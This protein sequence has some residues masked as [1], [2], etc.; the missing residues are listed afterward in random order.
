M[1]R[2][3]LSLL[4]LGAVILFAT[5]RSEAS[6]S[7]ALG[8]GTLVKAARMEILSGGKAI[9]FVTIPAGSPMIVLSSQDDGFLVKRS[10]A[11]APFKV[12]K[13]SLEVSVLASNS[14]ANQ[15]SGTS[16]VG[17]A[18]ASAIAVPSSSPPPA[19]TTAPATQPLP[20]SSPAT[21]ASTNSTPTAAQVNKALGIPLFGS[22]SLWEESD[23]MV[24]N[25]LRWP[26]ESKTSTEAGY[27]RYPYT[28]NS[29]TRVLGARSLSLFMQGLNDKV[30]RISILFANK[31]DVAF[32][33]SAQ[34]AKQQAAHEKQ[35]LNVTDSMIKGCQDAMRTDKSAVES[36]LKALLGGSKP[37]RVGKF[38][39]TTEAGQR[40]D[41]SGHS[42]LLFAPQNEYVALRIVPTSTLDDPDAV[43]KSFSSVRATLTN[44]V[45]RRASGDVVITDLPMVDQGRK[46]YCVPATFERVLRY[47]GLS[48]DMNVLAMAGQT[49]MGG[50][51]SIERIEGAT[52][53]LIR[54]AGGN[55]TQKSFSG[56]ISEIKPFIDAGKPVLFPHFSTEEFNKRVD[57]RMAR[58]VAMTNWDAW[59]NQ[60]LPSFK[61]TVPLQRDPQYGHI[62]LII[63]YNEKTREIAIS[64]SWG[65]A[66]TERWMTEDEA[67]QI[68]D[69]A[70]S[71]IE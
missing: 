29:E 26:Q 70:I 33:S 56:N 22:G 28:F 66:A 64:D 55:I 14:S 52:Y 60:F 39:S 67:R 69:S 6:T 37:A 3:G 17:S 49:G 42:F 25:R 61:K 2:S 16:A 1:M 45:E 35:A 38:S 53:N 34:E 41:W 65:Q 54:D 48:E 68:K 31:G 59:K 62:C 43:K 63:G 20:S 24:A 71:V 19:Q 8:S 40:W 50:G 13:D 10:D 51:T 46:G 36:A 18:P 5:D 23:A 47:Y 44:R 57:E 11:E 7:P 30:A 12:P 4:F 27:R 9:G 21:A 15:A 58:R 32:F